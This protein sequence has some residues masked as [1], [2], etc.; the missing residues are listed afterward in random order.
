MEG[1]L[2]GGRGIADTKAARGGRKQ[3]GNP[4]KVPTVGTA[5][6]KVP[7]VGTAPIKVPTVR[8][9]PIKVLTVGTAR[10][11]VPTGQNSHSTRR[12]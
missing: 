7:T 11:E 3:R 9:A 5:P 4:I 2:R 6:I 10:I 12:Y 1:V 8:T